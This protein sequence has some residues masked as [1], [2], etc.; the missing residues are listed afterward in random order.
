MLLI[1]YG[2]DDLP[3]KPRL[4]ERVRVQMISYKGAHFP[5]DIV[6]TGYAYPGQ[7]VRVMDTLSEKLS[8]GGS[9]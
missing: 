5:K 9:E 7:I 2:R 1:H 4:D 8:V 3:L 6:L